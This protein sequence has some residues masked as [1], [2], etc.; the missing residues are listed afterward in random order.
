MEQG[1]KPHRLWSGSAEREEGQCRVDSDGGQGARFEGKEEEPLYGTLE[2]EARAIS[3]E[4][5]GNLPFPNTLPLL[6]AS[7]SD[8]KWPPAWAMSQ[9]SCQSAPTTAIVS[10]AI[11]YYTCGKSP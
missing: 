2:A 9:D 8:Q 6:C 5:Q 4:M 3:T 7:W 1:E 10:F 11:T